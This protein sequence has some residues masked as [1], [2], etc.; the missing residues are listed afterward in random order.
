MSAEH[1]IFEIKDKKKT[2]L[3]VLPQPHHIGTVI[4]SCPITDR[5]L[6]VFSFTLAEV[7]E[8]QPMNN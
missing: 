1:Q 5:L 4:V 8:I 2:K 6:T 3:C 7:Y